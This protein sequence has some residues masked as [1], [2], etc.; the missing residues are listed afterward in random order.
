MGK[1]SPTPEDQYWFNEADI[2]RLY[3]CDKYKCTLSPELKK[4]AK[5]EL[6]EDDY[7]REQALEQVR[8]WIKKTD[9]I[10]DCRLDSN[11]LLRFL[12]QQKFSVPLAQETLLKY[13]VMRQQNPHWFHGT[14][15]QDPMVLDLINRGVAFALPKRDKFGR[16]VLFTV[17]GGID[18]NRH[19]AEGV[20]KAIMVA[21]E[22]CLEDEENQVR[23]FSYILDE[24]GITLNHLSLWNPNEM[25]KI[26]GVCERAMPMRHK[27]LDFVNLPTIATYVYEFAKG[28]MTQKL[29]NRITLHKDVNAL[30]QIVDQKIL[31]KEY[32]GDTELLEMIEMYKEEIRHRQPRLLAL[33][34]MR[35][36]LEMWKKTTNA[37][38]YTP[39]LSKDILGMT[40][41]FKR[42][43]ID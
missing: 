40:G 38:S 39:S 2:G 36:D 19:T 11:F 5:A 9:Y 21:F 22:S 34:R 16:R 37:S 30:T 10:R 25:N 31:P 42:L 8:H 7:T 26:W 13:I 15:M 1:G 33:D 3:V 14:G 29:R 32:G 20:M 43:E 35:V 28:L 27:R 41:S 23:G 4:V 18:P 6:R 17:G 12:R 24:G